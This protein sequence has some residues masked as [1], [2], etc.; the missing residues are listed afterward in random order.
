MMGKMTRKAATGLLGGA[1]AALLGFLQPVEAVADQRTPVSFSAN[2]VDFLNL[3]GNHEGYRGFGTIS[4]FAPMIPD[5]EI[6]TMTI[7]EVLAYQ[8]LI[9]GMGTKSS[10]V[11][12]YQFIYLTLAE[13]VATHGISHE[14]IF[15]EEVQTWLAR[16][17]MHDCGFY[18]VDASTTPLGN[19]LASRWAALPML[20]GPKAGKS[21]YHGDGL[22][23]SSIDPGLF[24]SVLENRFTW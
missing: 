4:D 8:Q 21:A 14:I 23:R 12:R 22:N 16:Q 20:S 17:L 6:Q 11:G 1:L 10:A 24:A 18:D 2:D 3:M 13:L 15:D 7:G 9:R 19:C 5:A